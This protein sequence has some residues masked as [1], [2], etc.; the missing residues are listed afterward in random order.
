M[1]HR[2]RSRTIRAVAAGSV[3][4][5]LAA[6]VLTGCST[7]SG[8]D[9]AALQRTV[10]AQARFAYPTV[11][12]LDTRCENPTTQRSF[13]CTVRTAISPITVRLA[14]GARGVLTLDAE[15]SVFTTQAV[16]QFVAANGSVPS[17]PSCGASPTIV[18]VAGA[19]V[20]CDVNFTDGSKQ[21]VQ[22]RVLDGAGD[23][24]LDT[25]PPPGAPPAPVSPGG[26]VAWTPIGR[27]VLGHPTTYGA[28]ANGVGLAW[29]DPQLLHPVLVAGTGDPSGSPGPWGGQVP[30]GQRGALAAAF[31]S[32]F[33]MGD[34]RGGWVGWGAVW[35]PPEAGDAS[36]VVQSNGQA[37]VGVWGRDVNGG[38]DVAYVRQNLTPLIDGGQPV[39]S[40]GSPGAWGASISGANTWRSALGI[41]AHGALV[42]AAG[43][44]ITPAVLAQALVAAGVQRAMELDINPSW[45]SFNTYQPG[46]DGAVHGTKVYGL[47]ADDKY[48]SPDS[49]DFIAMLVRPIVQA[50]ATTKLGAPPLH[51][52]IKSP[53]T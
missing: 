51:T 2:E 8:V 6:A 45:V 52:V 35:R 50:G 36:L 28:Q 17:L 24:R 33:K 18:A 11:G 13:T 20:P 34:I 15:Q 31:N 29:L 39:A 43:G 41:D 48:L 16:A 19:T 38:P 3:S 7:S 4:A 9:V 25:T 46:A 30:P 5:L 12:V 22:V 10:T 1:R 27:T 47:H 37:T 14:P 26:G 21:S 23:V 53:T 49:R 32:G 42:F 40:A 44:G